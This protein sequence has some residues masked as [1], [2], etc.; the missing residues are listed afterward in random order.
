M[1]VFSG[2]QAILKKVHQ[3]VVTL[4]IIPH[5]E[6]G[7]GVPI[8]IRSKYGALISSL[9]TKDSQQLQTNTE[10]LLKAIEPVNVSK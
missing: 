1:A 3:F 4:G 2:Q 10:S 5:L 8:N 6:A 7:V 9:V